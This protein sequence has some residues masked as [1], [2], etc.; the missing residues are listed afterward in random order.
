[1]DWVCWKELVEYINEK[2]IGTIIYRKEYLIW[3]GNWN[4]VDVYRRVLQKAE[5]LSG[6]KGEYKILKHIESELT[7]KDLFNLAYK[8]GYI[9]N[10]KRYKKLNKI[11]NETNK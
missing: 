10:Y 6:K 1:M 7:Y 4:S 9:E 2:P 11:L 8:D 3:L 5:Y